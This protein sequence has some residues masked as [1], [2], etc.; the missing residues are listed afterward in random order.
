LRLRNNCNFT[1][2]MEA[3]GAGIGGL[4]PGETGTVS[5]VEP[6]K[7]RDYVIPSRG[8]ASTRFWAKYGCDDQGRN[9]VIGDQMP[10]YPGGGCPTGGCTPPVDSFSKRHGVTRE[11]PPGSIQAKLTVSLFLTNSTSGD[12]PRNATVTVKAAAPTSPLSMPHI[13]TRPD[14][15]RTSHSLCTASTP[16][17]LLETKFT[18]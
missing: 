14:A 18:P 15:L 13:S 17:F 6:G 4:I 7:Y 5:R 10:Y 16:V 8:L 3:R 12:K 2:W 11:I 1:L 9:C